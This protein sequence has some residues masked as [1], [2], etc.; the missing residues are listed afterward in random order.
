ML[1]STPPSSSSSSN[2]QKYSTSSIK[3][4]YYYFQLLLLQ[5]EEAAVSSA[6]CC[7]YCCCLLLVVGG[8]GYELWVT[9]TTTTVSGSQY[10]KPVAFWDLRQSTNH[11]R[12][13]SSFT[14]IARALAEHC[15]YN[16]L[17]GDDGINFNGIVSI[18]GASRDDLNGGQVSSKLLSNSLLVD[19]GF[20]L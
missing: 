9:N 14:V 16:I 20:Q 8:G 12:C 3:H 18:D 1:W 7:C 10:L 17:D 5:P 13:W 4:H 19:S 6:W 2:N 11:W 15:L